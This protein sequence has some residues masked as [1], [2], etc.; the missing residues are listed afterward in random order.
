MFL[1]YNFL[2]TLFAPLWV[3]W[4]LLRARARQEAPNWKERQGEF[5]F[6]PD[7]KTKRIW[8]HAVSVGE[9]VAAMPILAEVRS[10]LPDHEIVLSVTTSSGHQTARER[11]TGLYDHLVYFPID[12]ARFQMAAMTRVRPEVVAVM[13]TELWLNFLWAAQAMGAATLLVNGRI[14]DRSFPRARKVRF[15]YRSLLRYLDRALMQ[16]ELDADRIRALGAEHAEVFGNCKFDEGALEEVDPVALRREFGIGEGEAVVVLGSTRGEEEEALVLDAIE[17]LD[18]PGLKIIH[19]PRHLER[20]DALA[21]A[22]AARFGSVARRSRGESG[23]Y[24]V[25]DTYGELGRVYALA[26]VAIVGGGFSN[27]G[28]QNLIQPLAHG[29]PVIHGPNM[30]NFAFAA[31]A[32]ADAGASIVASNADE[33]A[34]ALGDLLDEPERRSRM[35][36]EA[37]ALVAKHR[38]AARR[39]AEAI[40]A[41]CHASD[42]RQ[43]A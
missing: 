9:V 27:F 18:R 29:K 15:F 41:A 11:A 42:E 36:Q 22:V 32:A 1:L 3:P 23:R 30:Q 43:P 24:L 21:D 5:D 25:L 17:R 28:G 7:P 26:D 37:K 34:A 13:E 39:Y 12:V 33:L 10:L 20:A 38:G 14:S 35:G 2:L 19:A 6:P 4:M 16:T 8:I 31:R 40:A